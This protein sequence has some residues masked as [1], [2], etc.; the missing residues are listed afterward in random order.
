M[1]R[2]LPEGWA[3]ETGD[4]GAPVTAPWLELRLRLQTITPVIGGGV[5][6]LD[7]DENPEVRVSGIRGHLR[8][9]WRI[10]ALGRGVEW[11]DLLPLE[12]AIWGGVGD[13]PEET[14]ASKVRV[15][16]EVEEPGRL[17]APGTHTRSKWGDGLKSMPD[18]S[19]GQELAYAL[20][21]L[22]R[23][24]G[25]RR[26]AVEHGAESLETARY[27]E[28]ARFAL[29]LRIARDP[30]EQRREQSPADPSAPGDVASSTLEALWLWM[31]FGGIG[32]RTSRGFGALAPVEAPGVT[33]SG[34]PSLAEEWGARL[35]AAPV[36][37]TT[38]RLGQG[39]PPVQEG[40]RSTSL[41]VGPEHTDAREAH[42]MLVG[43]L[44]EFRQAAGVGRERK[45]NER[46][47][48]GP[49][50]WPEPDLLR[51]LAE[52]AHVVRRGW[53]WEH[54]PRG[55]VRKAHE[56]ERKRAIH[57]AAFG[58]PIQFTFKTSRDKRNDAAANC[59]AGV[60]T[61][62]AR[63]PSPLRLRIVACTGG[64]YLPVALLLPFRPED[65]TLRFDRGGKVDDLASSNGAKG[66][67]D[68]IA[69]ALREAKGDAALAFCN[70]LVSKRGFREV[71]T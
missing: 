62:Q 46:W 26:Q 39:L 25:E 37:E 65:V 15:E 22:Q 68:P 50:H 70:R 58:L 44:R 12:R 23:N 16:T 10:A 61:N 67:R 8:H 56:S 60:G 41:F 21:P 20:F 51:I 6:G 33:C 36:R 18:W 43:A 3:L 38:A 59:T 5:L 11:E 1:R 48:E 40:P 28:N 45:P 63:F 49:S 34:D 17:V 35:A 19:V 14:F 57:R 69:A 64:R 31:L 7:R 52:E 55:D 54:D 27:R 47:P 42:R 24:D 9:W 53:Q 30:G 66:A 71:R 13:S 2:R 32:G 29:R 4:L